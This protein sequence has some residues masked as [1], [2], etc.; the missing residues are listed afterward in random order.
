MFI[1][2]FNN[3]PSVCMRGPT[4]FHHVVVQA[5]A[6]RYLETWFPYTGTLRPGSLD[7][8]WQ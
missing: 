2:G 6:L 1:P 3:S 4:P 5:P 7:V 8:L